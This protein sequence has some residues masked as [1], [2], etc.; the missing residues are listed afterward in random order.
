M[1]NQEP[2]SVPF[3]GSNTG[4]PPDVGGVE[5]KADSAE[6]RREVPTSTTLAI[7]SARPRIVFLSGPTPKRKIMVNDGILGWNQWPPQMSMV[8]ELFVSVFL[9]FQ[10]LDSERNESLFNSLSV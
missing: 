8:G 2:R 6:P 10:V 3:G 1:A 4:I 9:C 7:A 5:A